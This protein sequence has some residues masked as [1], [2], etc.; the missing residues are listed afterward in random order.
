MT[1]ATTQTVSAVTDPTQRLGP[2]FLRGETEAIDAHAAHQ[3]PRA[4]V[5]GASHL[6][7]DRMYHTT[8]EGE[9]PG[10]SNGGG[11]N[12]HSV[13]SDR[14][15]RV[16][17]CLIPENWPEERGVPDYRPLERGRSTADR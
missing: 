16:S 13:Y 2:V 12:A 7:T 4:S 9:N 3:Q 15:T 11:P 10:R 8:Y 17:S 14:L 6:R 5:N 1:A